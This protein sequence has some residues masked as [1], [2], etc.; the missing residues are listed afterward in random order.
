MPIVETR[1]IDKDKLL[2]A[3]SK[4]DGGKGVWVWINELVELF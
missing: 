4:R 2:G 1:G 3:V